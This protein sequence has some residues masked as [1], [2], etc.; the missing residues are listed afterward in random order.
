[1]S[2]SSCVFCITLLDRGIVTPIVK[3]HCVL[4]TSIHADAFPSS[5]TMPEKSKNNK[6]IR[7]THFA[8]DIIMKGDLFTGGVQFC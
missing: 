5:H 7:N 3:M 8:T 1:M 4:G 2:L 6:L